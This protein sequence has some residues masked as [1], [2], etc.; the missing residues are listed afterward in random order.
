[1]GASPTYS[2]SGRIEEEQ[3][4]L[5][6]GFILLGIWR[7]VPVDLEVLILAAIGAVVVLFVL[8]VWLWFRQRALFRV[9]NGIANQAGRV[10]LP[11]V[12]EAHQRDLGRLFDLDAAHKERDDEI[13]G[14]LRG[15]VQRVGLVKFDAFDDVGGGLSFALALLDDKGSG[16]VVSSLYGRTDSTV[17]IKD[18]S[19]GGSSHELTPEE[20]EAISRAVARS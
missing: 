16:V 9:H 3:A 6:V 11:K 7:I 4:L 8:V 15:A 17:Y 5:A 19:R 12:L 20:K 1:M 2:F 14:R 10:D 13:D 18:V